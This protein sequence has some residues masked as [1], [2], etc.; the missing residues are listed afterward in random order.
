M[1]LELI[2]LVFMTQLLNLQVINNNIFI[3]Y[4]LNV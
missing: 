3:K 1:R 2:L 4:N